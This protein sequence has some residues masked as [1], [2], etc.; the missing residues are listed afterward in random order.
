MTRFQTLLEDAV[1]GLPEPQRGRVLEELA[2]DLEDMYRA[3]RGA[4][5][6]AEESARRTADR[7]LPG[8]AAAAELERLHRRLHRP[9]YRRLLERLTAGALRV[10]SGSAW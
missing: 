7:V 5:Y 1:A 10:S 9:P 4:G 2:A 3:Y 8:P 6:G